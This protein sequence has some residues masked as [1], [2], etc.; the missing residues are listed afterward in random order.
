[1]TPLHLIAQDNNFHWPGRVQS[2][3]YRIYASDKFRRSGA[4][5]SMSDST[6]ITHTIRMWAQLLFS[7]SSHIV[8]WNLKFGE[9]HDSEVYYGGAL[10]LNLELQGD[11]YNVTIR[12]DTIMEECC[13]V[14]CHSG[15]W[16]MQRVNIFNVRYVDQIQIHGH[17][18]HTQKSN[19]PIGLGSIS[20]M[21]RIPLN[22]YDGFGY[23]GYSASQAFMD[24]IDLQPAP[25]LSHSS[26][27][28]DLSKKKH[29]ETTEER[30]SRE[31][32]EL[33]EKI[34][35]MADVIRKQDR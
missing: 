19:D 8:N 34:S 20:Y 5:G 16:T 25:G 2:L 30:E 11:F 10:Q 15:N 21:E 28:V 3:V 26:L 13:D 12:F 31:F 23:S 4:M 33:K 9:N 6:R 7:D 27:S 17:N 14:H 29:V 24:S 18:G 1:M 35:G 32:K 22:N